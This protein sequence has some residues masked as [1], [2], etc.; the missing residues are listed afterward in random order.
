MPKFKSSY[1]LTKFIGKEICEFYRKNRNIFCNVGIMYTNVSENIKKE[2]LI[3]TIISQLK[4]S[5]KDVYLKNPD[6]KLDMMSTNDAIKAMHLSMKLKKSDTYIISSF[7]LISVRKI[8]KII[9]S[10]IGI[11]KKLL[12]IKNKKFKKNY[13]LG[14]NLK[15]IKDTKWKLKDNIDQIIDYFI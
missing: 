9:C 11:N 6:A 2:F 3:K 4:S 1:A 15:I 10:K 13:M 12:Y 5:K 7:K 8:F 14:N